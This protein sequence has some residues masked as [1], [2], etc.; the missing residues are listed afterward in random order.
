M[1]KKEEEEWALPIENNRAFHPPSSFILL[2]PLRHL[3]PF[4]LTNN[5]DNQWRGRDERE[6]EN[7]LGFCSLNMLNGRD[8]PPFN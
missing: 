4:N 5:N 6:E 1:Q 3:L 2:P 8:E 7:P